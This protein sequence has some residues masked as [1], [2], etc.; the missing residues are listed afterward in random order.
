MAGRGRACWCVVGVGCFGV[1]GGPPLGTR[2]LVLAAGAL[3]VTWC[4]AQ[5][6]VRSLAGVGGTG[7]G[8]G[9]V[10]AE[11]AVDLAGAR[12]GM[13]WAVRSLVMPMHRV[14]QVQQRVLVPLVMPTVGVLQVMHPVMVRLALPLVRVLQAL[15]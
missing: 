14:L 7:F 15:R 5:V 8:V 12:Q 9:C 2:R 11:C 3:L 6:V 10:C 4:S 13:Q 1:A